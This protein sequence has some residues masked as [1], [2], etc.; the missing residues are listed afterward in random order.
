M[1]N[2][3][4]RDFNVV[5]SKQISLMSSMIFKKVLSELRSDYRLNAES[6]FNGGHDD[7]RVQLSLGRGAVAVYHDVRLART[8]IQPASS[9]QW[10]GTRHPAIGNRQW[11]HEDPDVPIPAVSK[12]LR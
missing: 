2:V 9:A 6:S 1:L 3:S 5:M 10:I 7:R 8:A 12:T 4:R 11:K